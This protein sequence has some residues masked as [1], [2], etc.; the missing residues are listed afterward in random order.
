[1]TLSYL[2][3]LMEDGA[4]VLEKQRIECNAVRPKTQTLSDTSCAKP[5]V[6]SQDIEKSMT[7]ITMSI[8]ELRKFLANMPNGAEGGARNDMVAHSELDL[9]VVLPDHGQAKLFE[10]WRQ[11]HDLVS[12]I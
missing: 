8:V 7:F 11:K 1:M 12:I 4:D 2:H 5:I 3:G 6:A 9:S 10:C